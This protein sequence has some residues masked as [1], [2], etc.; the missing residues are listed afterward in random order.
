MRIAVFADNHGNPYS[1]RAVLK[2]ISN[3]GWFDTVVAAGD[4]CSGGSDPA[5]C[6]DMLQA[7]EAQMVYGNADEFVFASPKEP[8]A[9]ICR[10]GWNQTVQNSRWAA[11]KL[12]EDRISWL[13]E[14]PFEL[15]FSPTSNTWDDLLIVHANPKDVYTHIFPPEEIQRELF[16]EV[17]Q[18]DSDPV[19]AD[20]LL[21]TQ[22]AIMAYGHVHYTFERF[23]HG[24]RLVNVSPCS[25]SRFDRDRRAR[26]TL[27]TWEGEW[28]VERR[29]VV[30]DFRQERKAL[31]ASDM[32]GKAT[33][34]RFFE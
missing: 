31:L 16:G 11:G 12:G 7:A 22:A 34:A 20:L 30:Y 28:R 25:F 18:P 2:A 13:E 15:R 4:V 32:P 19:L 6:V 10:A 8:P 26:Y 27:F 14:Q 29:Y 21:G 24:I 33:Q 5:A 9:E 3:S 17:H 23:A 1:T